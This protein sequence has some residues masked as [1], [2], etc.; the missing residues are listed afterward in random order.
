MVRNNETKTLGVFCH[1][2]SE[3]NWN[4]KHVMFNLKPGL[5]RRASKYRVLQVERKKTFLKFEVHAGMERGNI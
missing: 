1:P 5:K 3:P 4:Q 2:T